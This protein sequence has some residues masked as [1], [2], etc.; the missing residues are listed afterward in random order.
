MS[1]DKNAALPGAHTI[2]KEQ[3]IAAKSCCQMQVYTTPEM[4]AKSLLQ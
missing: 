4:K 3:K 2:P 1:Q